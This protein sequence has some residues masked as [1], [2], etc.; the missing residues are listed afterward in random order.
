MSNTQKYVILTRLL[1]QLC[2][3]L[4]LAY[5]NMYLAYMYMVFGIWCLSA[6]AVAK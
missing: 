3:D 4:V 5:D 1:W 6:A 2:A